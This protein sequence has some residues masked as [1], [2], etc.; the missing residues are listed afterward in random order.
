MR[1]TKRTSS[2]SQSKEEVSTSADRF[3]AHRS[4]HAFPDTPLCPFDCQCCE[5]HSH[6]PIEFCSHPPQVSSANIMCSE[7]SA[8]V[9]RACPCGYTANLLEPLSAAPGINSYWPIKSSTW[10]VYYR[11]FLRFCDVRLDRDVQRP[12]SSFPQR[13]SMFSTVRPQFDFFL[14][15]AK[16]TVGS[17]E[18]LHA[19]IHGIARSMCSQDERFSSTNASLRSATQKGTRFISVTRSI[20]NTSLFVYCVRGTQYFVWLIHSDTYHF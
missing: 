20:Y 2:V 12:T 10:S 16:T 3:L 17:F 15:L 4:L 18:A 7:Y 11:E 8:Y 6:D 19:F 5:W 14:L 13:K 9:V 1:Y